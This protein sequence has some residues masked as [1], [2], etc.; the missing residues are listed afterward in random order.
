MPETTCAEG[1]REKIRQNYSQISRDHLAHLR[2]TGVNP[3]QDDADVAMVNANSIKLVLEHV[4]FGGKV[5]DAGCGTGEFVQLL[6]NA[7]SDMHVSGCDFSKE[8]VDYANELGIKNITK[9]DLEHLPYADDTFDCVVCGDVLE[10]VI[11][12]NVVIH[13]LLRVLKP[14]GVCIARTPCFEDLSKYLVPEYPYRYTHFRTFSA[15]GLE[16]L[17]DRLFDC[18]KVGAPIFTPIAVT[19]VVRKPV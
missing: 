10:H 8:Y 15:E 13:E 14:G 16:L 11:D 12:P 5:L 7:A 19:I 18:K 1:V 9:G 4:K 2:S 3:W 6:S 17:F